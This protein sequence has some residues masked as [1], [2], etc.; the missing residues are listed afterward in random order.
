MMKKFLPVL[1]L[2]ILASCDA[3]N[4]SGTDGNLATD[5]SAQDAPYLGKWL[6]DCV[7]LGSGTKSRIYQEIS[8]D[9]KIKLAYLTYEGTNCTGNYSLKDQ[10]GNPVTEAQY[11]QNFEQEAVDSIDENFYVLQITAITNS[12][13]QYVILYAND[14]EFYELTG[15]TNPHSTWNQWQGEAD[16]ANFVSNPTTSTANTF[17]KYHFTKSVLP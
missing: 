10:S 3:I 2:I 1:L 14:H 11:A 6:S 8:D 7:N 5:P 4:N 15:F 13:V 9:F 12:S 17:K 16:V